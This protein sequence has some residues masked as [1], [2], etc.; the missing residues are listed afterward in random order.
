MTTAA[1]SF[2]VP[3]PRVT[4][5]NTTVNPVTGEVVNPPSMTKQ[6]F[7]KE[8]DINNIIKQ[9]RVTGQLAHISAK[10]AQGSYRDLPD[11]LDFQESMNI[12]LAAEDSFSTLPAKV[13][14]RFGND[15]G[16]FLEFMADPKNREEAVKL[17]LVKE[18]PPP[19]PLP[20]SPPPEPSPRAPEPT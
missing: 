2:Y 12:V 19:E 4:E 7:A 10:A 5:D 17:G 16:Q 3:H 20:P 6:N 14:D 13:R 8:C 15:P 1:R 9:Y 18:L 11:P